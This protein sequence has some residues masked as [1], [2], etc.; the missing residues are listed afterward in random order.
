MEDAN[1]IQEAL[2]RSYGTP[3]IDE[4]DLEAGRENDPFVPPDVQKNSFYFESG[5][6]HLTR[7]FKSKCGLVFFLYLIF[8]P[9]IHQTLFYFPLFV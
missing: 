4:D 2:G 1:D 8:F 3:D 6:P 5:F 9:I 7:C